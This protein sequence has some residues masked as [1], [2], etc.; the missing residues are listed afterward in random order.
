[1][2][3]FHIGRG[4]QPAKLARSALKFMQ[5]ERMYRVVI[6][7]ANNPEGAASVRREVLARHQRIYSCHITDAGSALGVHI[8]P[9]GLILSFAPQP[10]PL[11][12]T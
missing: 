12:K 7:H 4:A 1:M 6:A 11:A 5:P 8:G 10:D 3:G 2:G 9:G